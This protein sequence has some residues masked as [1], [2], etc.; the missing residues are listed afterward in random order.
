[1]SGINYWKRVARRWKMVKTVLTTVFDMKGTVQFKFIPQVQTVNQAYCVEM[2]KQLHEDVCK[3][4]PELR[5]TIGFS[6]MTMLH[7][8]KCSVSSSF[9]LKKSIT[10]ME[11]PPYFPDLAPNDCCL[12]P[13]IK[14][15]LKERRLQD[16][17]KVKLS[18]CL[19]KHHAMKAYWG[20]E[21]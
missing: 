13:N 16:M 15:A 5:P 14:S 17:V 21:V 12:F 11:H 3:E 7:L 10:E 18:L 9:W 1:L 8:T 4:R 20:V 6:T 2:L 19:T